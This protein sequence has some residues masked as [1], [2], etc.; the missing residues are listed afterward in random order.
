MVNFSG[1]SGEIWFFGSP[2]RA[3]SMASFFCGHDAWQCGTKRVPRSKIPAQCLELA[4]TGAAAIYCPGPSE[5]GFSELA[6]PAVD[7]P[8][9]IELKKALPDT[10]D[11]LMASVKNSTTREDLRAYPQGRLHLSCDEGSCGH[12]HLSF[13]ILHSPRTATISRG[14]LDPVPGHDAQG[15]R[16]NWSAPILMANGWLGS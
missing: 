2:E 5:T 11:A 3:P 12:P 13:Q 15:R 16:G 4:S 6:G 7:I 14:W 8:L 10:E 1:S 9:R